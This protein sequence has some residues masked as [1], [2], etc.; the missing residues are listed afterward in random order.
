M[1]S[2]RGYTKPDGLLLAKPQ[3]RITEKSNELLEIEQR[4]RDL[5]RRAIDGRIVDTTFTVDELKHL[6][7]PVDS[8]RLIERAPPVLRAVNR[9]D[10]VTS[11]RERRE[12]RRNGK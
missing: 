2:Y 3:G 4:Q 1:I 10:N 12:S 11:L 9:P 6:G 5:A 8:R 7:T